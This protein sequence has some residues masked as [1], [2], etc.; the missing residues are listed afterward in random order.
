MYRIIPVSDEPHLSLEFVGLCACRLSLLLRQYLGRLRFLP[1][2]PCL[3][4][5][6]RLRFGLRLR[7]RSRRR[8]GL[9]SVKMK[10]QARVHGLKF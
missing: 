8:R 5:S 10:I 6:L 1:L 7:L 9:I 2:F 3:L 4:L